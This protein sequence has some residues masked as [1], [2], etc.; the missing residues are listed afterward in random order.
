MLRD[1]FLSHLPEVRD[2]KV[3]RYLERG[4]KPHY[5]HPWA[6]GCSRGGAWMA[7][8]AILLVQGTNGIG[9]PLESSVVPTGV[10]ICSYR[11]LS[12]RNDSGPRVSGSLG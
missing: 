3:N 6:G 2:G 5:T 7:M 10:L 12:V 8:P 1:P 11:C 4:W 9:M